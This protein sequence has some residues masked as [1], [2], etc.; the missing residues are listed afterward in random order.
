M[1]KTKEDFFREI[2]E[3][4]EEV[5]RLEKKANFFIEEN[6]CEDCNFCCSFV[7]NIPVSVIE[8]EY[9]KDRTSYNGYDEE[10]FI[11]FLNE[12]IYEYCPNYNKEIQGCGIYNTRPFVCRTFGYAIDSK[13]TMPERE[14]CYSNKV[15]PVWRDTEQQLIK[16]N[17]LNFDYY[18]TFFEQIEPKTVDDY[19]SLAEIAVKR[20]CIEKA[21]E[22]YDS[23]EKIFINKN[24]LKMF[25]IVKARK[26]EI[27]EKQEK[28]IKV[29]YRILEIYPDDIK[30]LSELV[31]LECSLGKY[32]DCIKHLKEALKSIKN[33]LM[34]NTL[35]L[36]Y[37]RKGEYQKALEVYDTALENNFENSQDLLLNKAIALQRM[38]RHEEAIAL[39]QSVLETGSDDGFVYISL[40]ISFQKIGKEQEAQVYLQKVKDIND[41][42]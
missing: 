32:D 1:N 6:P 19:M 3:I 8:R 4:Y 25:L 22:F 10:K 15:N 29:Y 24:R 21:L 39:L 17:S 28:A 7:M 16:F 5:S 34:Y 37:I 11:A 30:S 27:L 42:I 35:G 41:A 38:D 40:A 9:I 18:N 14:C 26:Y 31:N 2:D 36:S 33:P 12:E 23:A 20:K 13:V